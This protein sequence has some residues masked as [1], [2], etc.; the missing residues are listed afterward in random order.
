[1]ESGERHHQCL[2]AHLPGE[3][4]RL[5]R[6]RCRCLT[7]Q[8]WCGVDTAPRP[9]LAVMSSDSSIVFGSEEA[10]DLLPQVRALVDD[11]YASDAHLTAP[12]PASMGDAASRRFRELH[13]R[14]SRGSGAS[15]SPVLLVRLQVA[16]YPGERRQ[17]LSFKSNLYENLFGRDRI[18]ERLDYPSI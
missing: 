9:G 7:K 17:L 15:P 16:A 10:A 8:S 11:F 1:M 6:G 3:L 2:V 12:D 18:T 5:G 14:G 4:G 13:S